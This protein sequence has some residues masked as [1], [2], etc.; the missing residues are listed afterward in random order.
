MDQYGLEIDKIEIATN[1]KSDQAF[2]DNLQK[3]TVLLKSSKK[4][5]ATIEAIKPIVINKDEPLPSKNSSG[6]TEKIAA[7]L[8]EKWNVSKKAVDVTIEGGINKDNG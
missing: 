7:F 1:D 5:A 4:Q 3:V 6:E 8:S 2:P